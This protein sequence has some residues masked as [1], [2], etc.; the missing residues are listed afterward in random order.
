M[1]EQILKVSQDLEQG[2]IDADK[3]RSLLLGLFGIS[4]S[5][6]PLTVQK[7]DK[8]L[9]DISLETFIACGGNKDEWKNFWSA[10]GIEIGL[11]SPSSPSSSSSLSSFLNVYVSR[12]AGCD[13]GA[14]CGEGAGCDTGAGAARF[15]GS[16]MGLDA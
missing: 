16:T 13:T 14:G 4:G 5:L 6:Q 15:V 12:R 1:K 10:N 9:K 3:A 8:M 11:S 2:V 7:V